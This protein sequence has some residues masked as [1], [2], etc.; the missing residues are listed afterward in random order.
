MVYSHTNQVL[1]FMVI[2]F[3]LTAHGDL[4]CIDFSLHEHVVTWCI[5]ACNIIIR[6]FVSHMVIIEV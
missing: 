1:V 5:D 3:D 6:S 4:R 2:L